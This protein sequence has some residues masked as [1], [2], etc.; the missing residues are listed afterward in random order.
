MAVPLTPLKAFKCSYD[1][2]FH[3]FDTDGEL[4]AHLKDKKIH[5]YYCGKDPGYER[6]QRGFVKCDFHGKTLDELIAHKVETMLP[7]IVGERMSEKPKKL[8]HIVCEFCGESFGSLAGREVHRKRMHQA[9]QHV[10]C[11]GYLVVRDEEGND[12]R[13]GCGSIF[14][15]ASQLISHIEGGFCAY[16]KP[17]ALRQDREHKRMV[18]LILDDPEGFKRNMRGISDATIQPTPRE[19][20]DMSGGVGIDLL[21]QTDHSQIS[22]QPPLSPQLSSTASHSEVEWPELLSSD[23]S[24]L[25][26][27]ITNVSPNSTNKSESSFGCIEGDSKDT[28]SVSSNAPTTCSDDEEDDTAPAMPVRA[29]STPNVTQKLFGHSKAK[30]IANWDAINAAHQRNKEEDE[31]NNI[32]VSHFWDPTHTDFKPD[33]FHCPDVTNDKAPSYQCPFESCKRRFFN[34]Q[35]IGNHMR[36]SHAAQRNLCPV[37]LKDFQKLSSLVAHF[38]ASSQG[39]KCDVARRS[40]Y[41]A[42]LFELTGGL[43]QACKTLEEPVSGYK[44][45]PGSG[46]T[47]GAQRSEVKDNQW[48]SAENGVKDYDYRANSPTR[49]RI[50]RY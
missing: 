31:D 46:H 29:W 13:E 34:P 33:F 16:I 37:C 36:E 2:C 14:G 22:G 28:V 6:I 7:W 24:H 5:P 26:K 48:G 38:E 11:K 35:E 21:S 39:A 25:T 43:I 50:W 20:D 17:M 12:H 47:R 15:R 40:G 4:K 9:D 30:V 1:D 8:N 42:V 45:Q 41:S 19:V 32:F 10:I 44:L 27:S 18:K 3:S 23:I 49:V